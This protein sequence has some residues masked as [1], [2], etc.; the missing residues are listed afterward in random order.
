[1]RGPATKK[2][3]APQVR[4]TG[5]GSLGVTEWAVLKEAK[6]DLLWREDW[7]FSYLR[8]SNVVM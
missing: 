7:S 5:W 3:A 1:M 4:G 6:D 8:L 2:V